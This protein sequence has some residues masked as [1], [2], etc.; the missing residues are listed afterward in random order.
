[1]DVNTSHQQEASK[2]KIVTAILP[3]LLSTPKYVPHWYMYDAFGSKLFDQHA[4]EN[5]YYHMYWTESSLMKEH[6]GDIVSS[7]EQPV[8][9]LSELGAGSCTKTTYFIEELLKKNKSL[10]FIPIDI[11][12]GYMEEAVRG[13]RTKYDSLRVVQFTGDYFEGIDYLKGI[14]QKKLILFIGSSINNIPIHKMESF[15]LQIKDA[16]DVNDGFLVGI[17]LVRDEE[18]TVKMYNDPSIANKFMVP[19]NMN[20]LTQ[21]NRDFDAN[22]QMDDFSLHFKYVKRD[23][24]CGIIDKPHYVQNGLTSKKD[25]TIHLG[26]LGKFNHIELE[27][28]V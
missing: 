9:V 1:M 23:D 26:R 15:L 2:N 27:K 19:F 21:L 12:E 10:T 5:P 22:F 14:K 13:L 7:L 25:Q 16:M 18:G 17:N 4:M 8:E 6:V 3:G 11:A 20:A 28:R 24:M